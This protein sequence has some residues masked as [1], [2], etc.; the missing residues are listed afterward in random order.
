MSDSNIAE[1]SRN[2]NMTGLEH[3]PVMQ[4]NVFVLLLKQLSRQQQKVVIYGHPGLMA[5]SM[6]ANGMTP[7]V[8]PILDMGKHATS[9]CVV[10]QEEITMDYEQK[11]KCYYDSVHVVTPQGWKVPDFVRGNSFELGQYEKLVRVEIALRRMRSAWS[12]VHKNNKVTL[13]YEGR[14]YVMGDYKR[15]ELEARIAYVEAQSLVI[16]N[17]VNTEAVMTTLTQ[18][19]LD[20]NQPALA[21]AL[22]GGEEIAVELDNNSSTEEVI[23]EITE[24]IE[25]VDELQILTPQI[26]VPTQK[27]PIEIVTIDEEPIVNAVEVDLNKI[28]PPPPLLLFSTRSSTSQYVTHRSGDPVSMRYYLYFE[29]DIEYRLETVD[30]LTGKPWQCARMKDPHSPPLICSGGRISFNSC[31]GSACGHKWD[32]RAVMSFYDRTVLVCKHE[33][34]VRGHLRPRTAYANEKSGI[35]RLMGMVGDCIPVPSTIK[36]VT[37]Y[38]PDSVVL[39]TPSGKL[40]CSS[41]QPYHAFIK[42][43]ENEAHITI[44]VS[45]NGRHDNSKVEASIS[46][47]NGRVKTQLVRGQLGVLVGKEQVAKP[48]ELKWGNNGIRVVDPVLLQ[49]EGAVPPFNALGV[50]FHHRCA[51]HELVG[52]GGRVEGEWLFY[53][54]PARGLEVMKR[55]KKVGKLGVGQW[56][57]SQ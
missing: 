31:K 6:L 36:I 7:L 27:V 3:L 34:L 8:R 11:A 40:T 22:L 44:S 24:E 15:R 41:C 48:A 50:R 46:S 47:I 42:C 21:A 51:P 29:S 35:V 2:W 56:I 32:G 26:V 54:D 14:E 45:C 23:G 4:R 16:R 13:V 52:I 28:P 38:V 10:V 37:K 49:R 1:Y 19:V 20:G 5:T 55:L 43:F 25:E 9:F 12:M 39:E 30:G 18:L 57:L 17:P 33:A 53:D